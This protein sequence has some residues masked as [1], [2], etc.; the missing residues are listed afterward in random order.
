MFPDYT[1][2]S[3]SVQ[4]TGTPG[5][6][7]TTPNTFRVL[8]DSLNPGTKTITWRVYA[9]RDVILDGDDTQVASGTTAALV[10]GDNSG[11]ISFGGTWPAMGAYYRLI[12]SLDADDD[13]NPANDTWI[14]GAI[15]APELYDE[16]NGPALE[17]GLRADNPAPGQRLQPGLR[18]ASGTARTHHR[19]DGR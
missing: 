16:A 1:V 5:A 17:W 12:V 8:N 10:G 19:H 4:T 15:E 2:T 3:G 18:P 14:S 7:I 6:A 9:S 11:D 13:T